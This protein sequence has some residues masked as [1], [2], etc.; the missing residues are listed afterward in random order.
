[1]ILTVVLYLLGLTV[2]LAVGTAVGVLL[3]MQHREHLRAQRQ[4]DEDALAEQ[5][6]LYAAWAMIRQKP[7]PGGQGPAALDPRNRS[8]I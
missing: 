2:L 6:E 7:P 4:A 1:M 8:P 3:A 5:Q